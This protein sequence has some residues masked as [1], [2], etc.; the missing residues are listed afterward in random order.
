MSTTEAWE[1]GPDAYNSALPREREQLERLQR[2]VRAGR[3]M[4]QAR[5]LDL[6]EAAARSR[7]AAPRPSRTRKGTR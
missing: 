5:Q 1:R 7:R 6:I 4:S 3:G 2:A